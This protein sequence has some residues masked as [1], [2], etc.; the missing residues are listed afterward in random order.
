MGLNNNSK[1]CRPTSILRTRELALLASVVCCTPLVNLPAA[2]AV[3]ETSLALASDAWPEAVIPLGGSKA[4]SGSASTIEIV[5]PETEHQ[6]GIVHFGIS[7][8]PLGNST[9]LRFGGPR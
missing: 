3:N 7:G 2:Y 1:Y 9:A 4:L 8:H 6:M 5:P